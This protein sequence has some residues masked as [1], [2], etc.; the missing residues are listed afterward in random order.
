[1]RDEASK[2]VLSTEY[3]VSREAIRRASARA[4]ITVEVKLEP[5]PSLPFRR[6]RAHRLPGR[7]RSLKL[8]TDE[9]AA[10]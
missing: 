5:L 3:G 4:V 2:R 8:A 6:E 9:V 7:G 10:C 1:M